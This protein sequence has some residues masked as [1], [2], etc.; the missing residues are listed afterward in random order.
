MVIHISPPKHKKRQSKNG[1]TRQ[2]S[3]ATHSKT[4]QNWPLDLG[5]AYQRERGPYT[6]YNA[7]T[8]VGEEPLEIF[9][10]WLVWQAM[11]DA[12]ERR[13]A[14]TIQ[15]ILSL[16]ARAMGFGQAYPDQ[17]ECVM[18]NE[19]VH[20]P[21]VCVISKE[22]YSTQVEPVEPGGKHLV[23]KGS[24]ELVVE[25]RS[26]S[27]RR[28]QERK[29]RRSYFESGALVIWDVD[30]EKRKI[31]VYE[32]TNPDKGQEYIETDEISCA[33]I[34]GK[35]KR[36]VGDFFARDLSAEQVVGEAAKEW[37]AEA[38]REVV[39]LQA[40][41]RFG[42]E[43]PVDLDTRLNRYSFEQLRQIG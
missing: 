34:L 20:K 21:D 2:L 24:P 19:D 33:P 40:Q 10:G 8:V 27:N 7:S 12:E 39:L 42:K 4:R 18:V 17:F 13:I 1:T 28:T 30:Y 29:K 35:W 3:E 32:V 31:W 9:N 14:A 6:I 43:V 41:A 16:A 38:L 22:R 26:P 5:A 15:E 37:R 25:I 36:R 23:L 11:T